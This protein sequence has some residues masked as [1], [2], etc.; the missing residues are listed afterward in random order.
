MKSIHKIILAA[1]CSLVVL[2]Q[3]NAKAQTLE[4]LDLERCYDL[5]QANYPLIAEYEL[6]EKTTGF[7][8]DNISKSILPKIHLGGQASYQSEVVQFPF[9]IPNMELPT[10]DKDQYKLYLDVSQPITDFFTTV[11]H[12]KEL[13]NAEKNVK[14]KS[15][16]AAMYQIKERINQ[17]YFG[18]LLVDE[19]IAQIEILRKNIQS[20]MERNRVSIQN[21]IA[22]RSSADVLQAELLKTDKR[23]I[24]LQANRKAFT[25]IL[26]LFI[27]Q[28]IDENT[29]LV[30]PNEIALNTEINRPELAVFQAQKQIYESREKLIDDK[31]LPRFI[32]FG[33]GGYG[34]P[35]LNMLSND[36]D[37]FYIAGLRLSWDITSFYTKKNEKQKLSLQ[38]QSVAA[39]EN[40]FLFNTRL[41][42]ENHS[43]EIEKL[44]A[45]IEVD[46]NI[47]QLREKVRLTAQNQ[48]ENGVITVNDY[49]RYV[50]DEDEARQ[51]LIVQKMKRLIAHYEHQNT[52][53]N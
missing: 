38:Q 4:T 45:L 9:S 21:G 13:V 1:F 6:V 22:L 49:L 48:L 41:A 51:G 33:Q 31:S 12:Q 47:I 35:G 15:L 24:Q 5:A 28:N 10:I 53:G 8:L 43:G 42:M 27:G 25:E 17:L 16:D 3:E 18:I 11:K 19:Q 2:N 30:R 44:D 20:G 26:S 36:F 39:E 32:L 34:R 50:N 52:T 29:I 40:T 46:Q 14:I 37:L 23:I 7:S